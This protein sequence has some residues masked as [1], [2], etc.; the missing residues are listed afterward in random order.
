MVRKRGSRWAV[1]HGHGRLK[2][3]VIAY[4]RTKAEAEAQ[5]RAI[6]ASKSRGR[7][8]RRRKRKR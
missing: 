5:H 7:R 8:K 1:V 2:G 4:H 3:T 6:E